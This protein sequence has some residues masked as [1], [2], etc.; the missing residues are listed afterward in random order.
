MSS[1]KKFAIVLLAAGK[2]SRLGQAKQLL[3][4]EGNSLI[5]RAALISLAVSDKVVVVTG[6]QQKEIEEELSDLNLIISFNK[7]Y[8]EGIAS[9][10]RLGVLTAQEQFPDIE[11]VIIIVCDQ[12]YIS[13]T[14]LHQIIEEAKQT[15]KPIVAC[16]Y[17]NTFGTPV[18]F[19]RKYFSY[20]LHL[21]G[22][23]G[24]KKIIQ[25][26]LDDVAAINFPEGDIDIDTMDDYKTI[27]GH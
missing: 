19:S 2:S 11:A 1:Q 26:H 20:L 17:K 7:N 16:S 13:S 14:L 9:S 21:A 3:K 22:D 24:A 18:F 10:I 12:P 5:K 8:E 15:A 25:N 4:V 23:H 27:S 6:A